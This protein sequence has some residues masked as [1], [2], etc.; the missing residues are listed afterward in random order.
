MSESRPGPDVHVELTPAVVSGRHHWHDIFPS[1]QSV[2]RAY[3]THTT[4]EVRACCYH[5]RRLGNL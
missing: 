1:T 2:A 4:G 5:R 3:L